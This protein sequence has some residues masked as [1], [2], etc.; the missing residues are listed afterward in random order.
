L[1]LAVFCGAYVAD[2]VRGSVRQFL[3]NDNGQLD[4]AR[5]LGFTNFQLLWHIAGPQ[6]LRRLLPALLAQSISLV[7]D[8]SLVSVISLVELTKAATNVVSTS[9][10]SFETWIVVALAYFILNFVLSLFC[11]WLEATW[12]SRFET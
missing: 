5:M 11:K 1:S 8:S 12:T 6:V 9:F 2:I 7:K 3:K 4:A 10:R